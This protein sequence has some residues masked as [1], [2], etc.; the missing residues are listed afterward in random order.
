M[1]ILCCFAV[2]C[3]FSHSNGRARLSYN[4]G[5]QHGAR[6]VLCVVMRRQIRLALHLVDKVCLRR[7]QLGKKANLFHLPSY[8]AKDSVLTLPQSLVLYVAVDIWASV[9][10]RLMISLQSS[11]GSI[12]PADSMR[13]YLQFKSSYHSN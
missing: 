11:T 9:I 12:S 3:V 7:P 4:P 6:D 5:R 2:N 8:V 1:T 13:F 10:F